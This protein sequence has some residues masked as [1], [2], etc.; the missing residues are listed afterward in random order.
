MFLAFNLLHLATARSFEE[1]KLTEEN[2]IKNR[3]G[4]DPL[5]FNS[6]NNTMLF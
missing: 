2:E 3:E 6:L 4:I 1:V 5:L